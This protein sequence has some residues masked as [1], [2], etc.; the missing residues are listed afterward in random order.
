MPMEITFELSDE[1]LDHFRTVMRE[2][3]ERVSELD[4]ETV[5]KNA[6]ELINQIRSTNASEFVRERVG[7]METLI[8]MIVDPHWAMQ[9]EDRPKVLQALAYFAEPDDLIPDE[10]PGLGFLDDA[11]MIEIVCRDLR[12]EIEA[13]RDFCVFRLAEIHLNGKEGLE[14][15]RSEWL[16]DRR[17][18]LHLRMHRRRRIREARGEK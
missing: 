15:E 9:P 13:Y 11:I 7:L 10:V 2:S 14:T 4:D 18:Q 3:R 1:D 5:I 12:H 17:R 16:E 8:G 6:R